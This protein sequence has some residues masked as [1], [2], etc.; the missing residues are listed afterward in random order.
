MSN[1]K[2][3]DLAFFVGPPG[4]NGLGPTYGQVCTIK[5]PAARRYRFAGCCGDHYAGILATEHTVWE[6]EWSNPVLYH[7]S[8]IGLPLTLKVAAEDDRYLRKLD[9]GVTPEEITREIDLDK[10]L[11]VPKQTE[12]A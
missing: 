7:H 3:G 10:L 9:G 12:E 8:P 4:F 5:G 11:V 1:V 6:V 2:P